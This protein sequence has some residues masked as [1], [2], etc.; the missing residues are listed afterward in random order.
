MSPELF[1][2]SSRAWEEL[3]NSYWAAL[4]EHRRGGNMVC[5][6]SS[7]D[8]KRPMTADPIMDVIRQVSM[9]LWPQSG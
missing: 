9:S 4:L 7:Q 8:W 2:R 6:L 5:L 3:C 1:L